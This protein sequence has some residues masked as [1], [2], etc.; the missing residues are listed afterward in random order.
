MSVSCNCCVLS[1]RRLCVGLITR[2]EES[3]RMCCVIVC[4]L[5]TS[6]MSRPWPALYR[7]ATIKKTPSHQPYI[8]T[9]VTLHDPS[10]CYRK[11]CTFSN[12]SYKAFCFGVDVEWN[13]SVLMKNF[14]YSVWG[15]VSDIMSSL[16]VG[17]ITATLEE[18]ER[19]T[20]RKGSAAGVNWLSGC[21]RHYLSACVHNTLL[22][23][24]GR[25]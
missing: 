8:V 23:T 2:P 22:S 5:E 1:G 16:S 4:D 3:N 19:T 7:S 12:N 25:P 10:K 18:V 9:S 13:I 14:S 20:L 15:L 21:C 17:V 24:R 11:S 6:W